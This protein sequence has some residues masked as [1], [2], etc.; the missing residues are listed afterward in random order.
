MPYYNAPAY[1]GRK[2]WHGTLMGTF[3]GPVEDVYQA[4]ARWEYDR[5][6]NRTWLAGMTCCCIRNPFSRMRAARVQ[7][8]DEEKKLADELPAHVWVNAWCSQN[9]AGQEI[10]ISYCKV[11]YVQ[12]ETVSDCDP[13]PAREPVPEAMTASRFQGGELQYTRRIKSEQTDQRSS[14]ASLEPSADA[15]VTADPQGH[16]DEVVLTMDNTLDHYLDDPNG[17]EPVVKAEAKEEIKDDEKSEIKTEDEMDEVN[18]F[19]DMADQEMQERPTRPC[20]TVSDEDMPDLVP[21]LTPMEME[22]P[23][24]L[25]S[26]PPSSGEEI[27]ETPAEWL[28]PDQEREGEADYGGMDITATPL[29]SADA[30][31]EL[32]AGGVPSDAIEVRAAKHRAGLQFCFPDDYATL[33]QVKISDEQIVRV[34]DQAKV[35][36]AS[37]E[38]DDESIRD[39]DSGPGK[40]RWC[41]R[42]AYYYRLEPSDEGPDY[43][44]M[45][46]FRLVEG[47]GEYRFQWDPLVDSDD[48]D[49]VDQ[50]SFVLKSSAIVN[51]EGDVIGSLDQPVADEYDDSGV[52]RDKWRKVFGAE[53]GGS[54]AIRNFE[55]EDTDFGVDPV[56]LQEALGTFFEKAFPLSVPVI[57]K[58]GEFQLKRD[59]MSRALDELIDIAR[60]GMPKGV[61]GATRATVDCGLCE[62]RLFGPTPKAAIGLRIC[63]VCNK[64][65]H[66]CNSVWVQGCD[67]AHMAEHL[68]A[69]HMADTVR[70]SCHDVHMAEHMAGIVTRGM[71]KRAKTQ[72]QAARAQQI[73]EVAQQK[74]PLASLRAVPCAGRGLG[75]SLGRVLHVL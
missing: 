48:E 12:D 29:L 75:S 64:W 27:A 15:A 56:L 66:G 23:T 63:R 14:E 51:A 18:G 31:V 57:P 7:M 39:K 44:R 49:R 71:R 47:S 68:A 21:C 43:R 73:I 38:S 2:I 58:A 30:V 45:M 52:H 67:D 65:M 16:V 46:K 20:P 22:A 10:G 42:A 9:N 62:Q 33:D 8:T 69:E 17:L 50:P 1:F 24:E 70:K 74:G 26:E 40:V 54:L 37:R 72:Q 41:K 59:N 53:F 13:S 36:L 19:R 3:M 5:N 28:D 32:L 6:G 35:R 60:S 34:T 61:I 11:V 55:L 4:E 25:L